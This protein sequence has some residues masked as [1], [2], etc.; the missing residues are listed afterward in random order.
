MSCEGLLPD[1]LPPDDPVQASHHLHVD[2]VPRVVSE[3]RRFVR[4]HAPELPPETVE[5]LLLLTSELVSNAVLHARTE[6]EVG[7]TVTQASVVVTVHDLDLAMPEQDPYL[8]REGGWGLGLVR[9]LA[10]SASMTRDPAGGKTAWFR[11]LRGPSPT[12]ADDAAARPDAA[13]RDS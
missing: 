3:A 13:V 4:A 9:A 2:P 1:V 8:H 7:L 10:D 11:L 5:V 6:I 12:V